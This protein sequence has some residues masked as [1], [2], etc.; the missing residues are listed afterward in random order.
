MADAS[1]SDRAGG[2]A[3]EG[4][5]RAVKTRPLM[6]PGSLMYQGALSS[7]ATDGFHIIFPLRARSIAVS[8]PGT[9]PPCWP[10]LHTADRAGTRSGNRR[11]PSEDQH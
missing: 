7:V 9:A 3:E 5:S 6:A 10:R 11:E 2:P 1:P 4:E 8:V